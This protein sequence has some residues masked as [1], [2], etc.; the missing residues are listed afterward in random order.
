MSRFQRAIG[1]I[2]SLGLADAP[3][4][5]RLIYRKALS[6]ACTEKSDEEAVEHL[7]SIVA[8]SE[9]TARAALRLLASKRDSYETDRAYRVLE[10]AIA[11]AP[12]GAPPIELR[13]LFA[14]EEAL[15]RLPV[16]A[17]VERLI[18]LE[19]RLECLWPSGVPNKKDAA[20]KNA[21]HPL[22]KQLLGPGVENPDPV[23]R[24]NLAL[25]IASHLLALEEQGVEPADLVTSYFAA[26]RKRV[27]RRLV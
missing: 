13:E 19:P 15:G 16:S 8:L 17:A 10:A 25:S 22:A 5:D 2:V 11:R 4:D 1:A 6:V 12:V 21:S 24:S 14:R 23:V 3:G 20:P 18:E 26:H 7:Q 27:V 9:R